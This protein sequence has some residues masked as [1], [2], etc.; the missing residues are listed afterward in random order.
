VE[1]LPHGCIGLGRAAEVGVVVR[2][3]CPASRGSL[4]IRFSPFD[5][6]WAIC[7]PGAA[8]FL[9]DAQVL[10]L[11][12]LEYFFISVIASLVAYS[13][14]RLHDGVSRFF[15]VNDAW[16]VAKAVAFAEFTTCVLL[17]TFTRLDNIP[18]SAPIIHALILFAGL[19]AIRALPQ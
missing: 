13:V 14:F 18:R 11:E 8:L 3:V 1:I 4:R 17:F 19:L 9:R 16:R 10:S 7:S 2:N 12:G 6:I 5:T 15:T